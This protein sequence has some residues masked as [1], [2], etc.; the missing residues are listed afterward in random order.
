MDDHTLCTLILNIY[1]CHATNQ[2]YDNV[3]ET[4]AF[5]LDQI[6]R[7]K[8][9]LG[10]GYSRYYDLALPM[11]MKDVQKNI[12]RF[13]TDKAQVKFSQRQLDHP[14]DVAIVSKA[15]INWVSMILKRDCQDEKR[16]LDRRRASGKGFQGS[17]SLGTPIGEGQTLE[18]FI[19]ADTNP[20]HNLID[21]ETIRENQ[22]KHQEILALLPEKLACA[23]KKYS[24]CNCYEIFVRQN[25]REPKQTFKEIALELGI[26]QGTITGHW[27]RKCKPLL[28]ELRQHYC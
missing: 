24:Q 12:T 18:D 5:G 8:A 17:I 7:L 11:T 3:A 10:S 13:F 19:P 4:L 21:A 14:T 22:R 20:M 2:P 1:H 27:H 16:K 15:F 25:L 28:D 26:S 6:P 23:S 9:Y